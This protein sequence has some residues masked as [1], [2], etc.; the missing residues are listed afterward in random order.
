MGKML[1]SLGFDFTRDDVF[2]IKMI[3]DRHVVLVHFPVWLFYCSTLCMRVIPTAMIR[4]KNFIIIRRLI[5]SRA[6]RIIYERF[7]LS[8]PANVHRDV[9]KNS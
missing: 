4:S 9:N 6:S 3:G 8:Q 1:Q 7:L 2:V 5:F